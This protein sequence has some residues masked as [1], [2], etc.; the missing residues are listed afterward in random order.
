[1][2]FAAEQAIAAPFAVQV[3]DARLALD[4]P[5]GFSDSQFTGSPRLIELA[6]S[7]TSASNR[8]LLFALEDGDL[9]RF[10]VGDPLELRRTVIAVTPK[11]MERERLTPAAF[12]LFVGEALRELGN[13]PQEGD[14]AK[15]LDSQPPGRTALLGGLRKDADVVSVL[16]GARQQGSGRSSDLPRYL[17]STNTLM[18][19]R[20]KALSLS[21]FSRYENAADLDWIRATTSRW[22]DELQ[23]LNAR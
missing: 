6:E 9:R 20:G 17:I 4:A 5:A 1:M 19:V 8:I 10:M 15:Y 12:A 18:L 7:L 16:Q 14:F 21:I 3:G 2:L 13:A 22:V 23:R 11:G